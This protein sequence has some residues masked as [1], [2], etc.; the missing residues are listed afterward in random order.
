VAGCLALLQELRTVVLINCGA[1]HFARDLQP[2][3][4]QGVR[5][6]VVDSHRPVCPKYNDADDIECVLLLDDDDPLSLQQI[7]LASD[8]DRL[9]E[10]RESGQL[11]AALFLQA[12]ATDMMVVDRGAT[13]GSALAMASSGSS[14]R[15]IWIPLCRVGKYKTQRACA[16]A[17]PCGAHAILPLGISV[18]CHLRI[19]V[20]CTHKIGVCLR[21]LFELQ[22]GNPL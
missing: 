1:G 2:A 11:H 13:S 10:E 4:A 18:W 3:S 8:L 9:S 7:P 21:V 14:G 22:S 17:V 16:T 19:L 5:F 12:V 15:L 20:L 6:V